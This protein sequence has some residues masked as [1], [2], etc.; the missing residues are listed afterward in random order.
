MNT[1][2]VANLSVLFTGVMLLV[3]ISFGY[4]N[5]GKTKKWIVSDLNQ[6]LQQTLMQRAEAWTSQD[7]LQAY[8]HLSSLLG[9]PISIESYNSDFSEALKITEI[10]EKSGI[11][12]C[13]K[14]KKESACAPFT[15][16]SKELSSHYLK[17]DT[18]LW[19]SV[20]G[21]SSGTRKDEIG[22]SFQG[23]TECSTLTLLSLCNK[24]VPT[25]CLVIAFVSSIFAFYLFRPKLPCVENIASSEKRIVY[26][27]LSLSY[28]QAT[29]YRNETE[30]LKLTPLQYTLMEMFFRISTHILTRGEICETLWPGKI[31]ADET[32][33]TL[34]RRLRPLIEEQTNLKITT[35]R[36]RAY[37]LELKKVV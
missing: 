23:Y 32:L 1:R 25:T 37:I 14:N 7:S 33:N 17:S 26:G 24:T 29:F 2:L 13:V 6:A 20:A 9:N 22:I 30:K 35:D 18:I 16:S 11:R 4:H 27:N 28:E 5:Y 31:N 10:K 8:S 15:D 36:G 12:I 34:V 19:L 21:I 3:S